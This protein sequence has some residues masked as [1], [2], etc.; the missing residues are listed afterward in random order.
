[1]QEVRGARHSVSNAN[2]FRVFVQKPQLTGHT[3]KQKQANS[4]IFR[5]TFHT[6]GAG[7][8]ITW[9]TERLCL[10][11]K[12]VIYRLRKV[13]NVPLVKEKLKSLT[14]FV[15]ST[16]NDMLLSNLCL[17]VCMLWNSFL[18]TQLQ[19]EAGTQRTKT[20]FLGVTQRGETSTPAGEKKL[21]FKSIFLGRLHWR[22]SKKNK[23]RFLGERGD[24]QNQKTKLTSH[25]PKKA[26][27]LSLRKCGT[28]L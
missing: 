21:K 16:T 22:V 11:S 20:P 8:G 26:S 5:I 9:H 17:I 15:T 3:G 1:M 10:R 14:Y 19:T 2:I 23:R 13:W 24:L 27:N 18:R 7:F 25:S 28:T 12:Y 6:K 4:K